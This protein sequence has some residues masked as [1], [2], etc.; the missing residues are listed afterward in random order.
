MDQFS[1]RVYMP[2]VL[3][4]PNH[5]FDSQRKI[6]EKSQR[7]KYSLSETLTQYYPFAGRQTSTSYINCN[8]EGVEFQE[9]RVKSKLSEVLEKS[10]DEALDL[11]LPTGLSWRGV[12]N[13]AAL[14][15]V[16]LVHF[17]CGGMAMAV[18][19]SHKLADAY[20]FATFLTNWAAGTCQ[21]EEQVAP[22]FA[23]WPYH[24][25]IV[26]PGPDETMMWLTKRFVF[27]N[28]KID[29]LKVMAAESGVKNPTRVG[30]LTA[31]LYKCA[32]DASKANTG[33]FQPAFMNQ[34]V[35]MR[36]KMVP[37]WP[38]SSAGNLYWK[39][40]VSTKD[41]SD[42]TLKS[43][44]EQLIKGK[45][46]I[47]GVKIEDWNRPGFALQNFVYDFSDKMYLSSSL[48]GFPFYKVDFGWGKPIKVSLKGTMLDNMFILKDTP[49]GDGIE[50]I[51]SLNEED[52]VSFQSQK[53]LSLASLAEK[54]L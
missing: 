43:I 11:V 32:M 14:V 48:C 9:A 28:S 53:E 8:D 46:Q 30:V 15:I 33:S 37:P 1:P 17:D 45:A 7:L 12:R 19:M 21:P 20:A 49:S 22:H 24:E 25:A 18:C 54:A 13:N 47:E 23:S 31:L 3:F 41:E 38:N 39:I 42:A 2:M 34:L 6:V 26:P 5:E 50:A 4:Y 10:E 36:S 16:R 27:H 52:M 51:V 40:S 44:T 29:Q 35:N